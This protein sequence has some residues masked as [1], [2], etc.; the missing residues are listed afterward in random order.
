M[1]KQYAVM[2]LLSIFFL[3]VACAGDRSVQ[4]QDSMNP[5]EVVSNNTEQ[6]FAITNEFQ[7]HRGSGPL[8]ILLKSVDTNDTYIIPPT[9]YVS[10]ELDYVI[11]DMKVEGE[12]VRIPAKAFPVAVHV[13]ESP[14]C[15][16]VRS[17]DVLIKNPAHYNLNGLGGLLTPQINPV[18]PCSPEFIQLVESVGEFTDL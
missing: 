11:V 15:T 2:S 5:S 7:D 3:L 18:S 14:E 8:Y 6:F 10:T 17:L 9:K 16:K 4:T 13:C 1:I 12:C